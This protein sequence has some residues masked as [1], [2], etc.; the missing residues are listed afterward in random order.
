MILKRLVNN[1]LVIASV[2]LLSDDT[3]ALPQRRLSSAHLRDLPLNTTCTHAPDSERPLG[4]LCHYQV[5]NDLVSGCYIKMEGVFRSLR[6]RSLRASVKAKRIW[7][8]VHANTS[9]GSLSAGAHWII[10][11]TCSHFILHI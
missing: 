5:T 1:T 11:F 8:K 9:D 10:A 3:S 4:L 7:G 2:T 6:D